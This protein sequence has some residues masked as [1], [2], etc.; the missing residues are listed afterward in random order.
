MPRLAGQREDYLIKA[1]RDYKNGARSGDGAQ[2]AEV[3]YAL[4]DDDLKAVAHH[5]A[6]FK[7][8]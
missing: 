4:S 8:M 7:M 2:M 3:V 6:H 1:L 5:I